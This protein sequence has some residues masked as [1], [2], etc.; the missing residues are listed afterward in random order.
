MPDFSMRRGWHYVGTRYSAS[1]LLGVIQAGRVNRSAQPRSADRAHGGRI[2][3]VALGRLV[4]GLQKAWADGKIT[5][6]ESRQ[7]ADR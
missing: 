3:R 6:T 5:K 7:A 4:E 2:S 1:K